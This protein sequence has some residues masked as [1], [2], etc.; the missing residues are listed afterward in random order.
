MSFKHATQ[1]E[2]E[3]EEASFKYRCGLP[4]PN[5]TVSTGDFKGFVQSV[6]SPH[7]SHWGG[8]GQQTR[9]LEFKK[10]PDS[11]KLKA[12]EIKYY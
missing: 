8:G 1:E 10:I 5:P 4:P 11:A 2:G 3:G 9:Q 7:S 6:E 12:L